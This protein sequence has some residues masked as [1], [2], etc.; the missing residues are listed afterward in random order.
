[1]EKIF[2]RLEADMHISDL[3]VDYS[4]YEYDLAIKHF[5]SWLNDKNVFNEMLY[6]ITTKDGKIIN[7]EYIYIYIYIY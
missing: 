7:K 6:K 4:D 3:R 1:M 2:Y 5:K